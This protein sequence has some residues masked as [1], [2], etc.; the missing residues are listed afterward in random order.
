VRL[1]YIPKSGFWFLFFLSLQEWSLSPHSFYKW[2]QFRGLFE[3]ILLFHYKSDNFLPVVFKSGQQFP[4]YFLNY[5]QIKT[6]GKELMRDCVVGNYPK[7]LGMLEIILIKLIYSH[8]TEK[9]MVSILLATCWKLLQKIEILVVFLCSFLIKKTYII[10]IQSNCD[11][12]LLPFTLYMWSSIFVESLA[13][14]FCSALAAHM[15]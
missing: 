7:L 8:S 9:L 4:V 12:L 2:P 13:F 3:I 11:K 1:I 15:L 10:L 5:L 6:I 14:E